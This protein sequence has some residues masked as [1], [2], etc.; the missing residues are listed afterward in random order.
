MLLHG[1]CGHNLGVDRVHNTW[2]K[3][4]LMIKCI[5]LPCLSSIHCFSSRPYASFLLLVDFTKIGI[6]CLLVA[7]GRKPSKP[8]FSGPIRRRIN[9]E[10]RINE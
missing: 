10:D 1:K 4:C 7:N 8:H 2:P 6:K 5:S 3:L 9:E